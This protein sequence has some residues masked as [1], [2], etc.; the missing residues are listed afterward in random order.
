MWRWISRMTAILLSSV[1]SSRLCLAA[2]FARP[3]A[4]RLALHMIQV[5]G[6]CPESC[7]GLVLM[8]ASLTCEGIH[9][10]RRCKELMSPSKAALIMCHVRASGARL[11]VRL[12]SPPPAESKIDLQSVIASL[13]PAVRWRVASRAHSC[14]GRVVHPVR[15]RAPTHTPTAHRPLPTTATPNPN[16]A[17]PGN[18]RRS[19][20]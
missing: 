3:S 14:A 2:L 19:S 20:T 13:K 7:G 9:R 12:A 15:W 11:P 5:T 17:T 1:G 18:G 10:R 4:K 8:T 6:R 16:L